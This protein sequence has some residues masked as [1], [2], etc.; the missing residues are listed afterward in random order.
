MKKRQIFLLVAFLFFAAS[1]TGGCAN[2][3]GLNPNTPVTITMWHNYGGQMKDAITSMVD[4]FNSSVG[5][6]K[7]IIVNVTY[8]GSQ[9]TIHDKL[10]AAANGDPGA[11]ELPDITTCYPKTALILKDKG[12]V[13]NLND[14]FSKKELSGYIPSFLEEGTFADGGL[15]V[16]PTAK[17]SEVLFLNQTEFDRFS[18][19]TGVSADSLST[20]EGLASTAEAY[21]N[22]TDGLTPDIPNDGKAFFS[23]DSLYNFAQVGCAQLGES[24]VSEENGLA[25]DS[26]AF[27]KVWNIYF[28]C[29]VKGYAAV[30]NPKDYGSSLMKTGGVV[31]SIGSTAGTAF[32]GN[33][34]TYSDGTTESVTVATLPYPVFDGGTPVV[35]QRG[36]GMCVTKSDE[37]HEYA[38]SIF[39]KW[40]T[41]AQ[42]NLR[43]VS[44]TGYLPVSTE[45]YGDGMEQLIE[46]NRDTAIGNMLATATDMSA[47]Y[48][49]Y[50]PPVFD[51]VD[52]LESSFNAALIAEAGN[53]H[54][55]YVSL[56]PSEGTDNA[57]LQAS[58]GRLENFMK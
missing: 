35:M 28:D 54:R 8:V 3:Y 42:N 15:Y 6:E 4:D 32:Y 57:F 9:S 26:D 52:A 11:P 47:D 43:F 48:E 7:G 17:S 1:L 10:V 40:F 25:T 45:A 38:A 14:W 13:V 22:W 23:I 44:S 49:Y 53:A 56:L 58:S 36:G 20:F 2:R 19:A 21:Y 55:I 46:D 5:A 33:T 34:V 50:I 16:F 29:A 51:G 12:R 18:S 30:M 24:F 37:T 31:C 41:Q 27:Q 39:L